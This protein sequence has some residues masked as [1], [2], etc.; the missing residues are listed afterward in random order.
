MLLIAKPSRAEVSLGANFGAVVSFPRDERGR[1]GLRWPYSNA[2]SSVTTPG[3]RFGFTG[4]TGKHEGYIDSTATFYS[5]RSERLF[6]LTGNY[7]HNFSGRANTFFFTAGGG[8]I[9]VGNEDGDGVSLMAGGGVGFRQRFAGGAGTFR[10]ELR[11][12]FIPGSN[13]VPRTFMIGIKLGFDL[14]IR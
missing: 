10:E 11:V 12:D 4:G 14:W 9:I 5:R 1:V 3:I 13:S 7:Q 6:L 8:P 2:P